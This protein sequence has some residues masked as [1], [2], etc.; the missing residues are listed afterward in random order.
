MFSR[1]VIVDS[2]SVNDTPRV[3]RMLILS[4][5]ATSDDSRGVIYDS[6]IFKIQAAGVSRLN[7]SKDYNSLYK[8]FWQFAIT[9]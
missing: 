7:F 4:D 8:L 6:N 1:S 2:R 9:E 3:I 5:A